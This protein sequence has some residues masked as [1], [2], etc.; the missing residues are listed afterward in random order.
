MV[1][2]WCAVPGCTNTSIKTPEKLF[3]SL[4]KNRKIRDKW[5]QLARRNPRDISDKTTPFFCEDHFC[6][7]KHAII[8]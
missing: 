1:Y 2:K 6:V 5:M 4:P 8:S 3:I 7:S